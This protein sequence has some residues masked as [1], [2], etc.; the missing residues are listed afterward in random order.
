MTGL[1][2]AGVCRVQKPVASPSWR[3]S[4]TGHVALHD[5]IAQPP[6]ELARAEVHIGVVEPLEYMP[7]RVAGRLRLLAEVQH[8]HQRLHLSLRLHIA[9]HHAKAHDRSAVSCQEAWDNRMERT[10]PPATKLAC[11]GEAQKPWPRFCRLTPVPGT[12]TP[13]PHVIRL[14]EADH[15]AVAVHRR[16]IDSSAQRRVVRRER[17]RP[18]HVYL[19]DGSAR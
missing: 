5:R 10:L 13:E 12:T 4:L 9:A 16:Q 3:L 17:L 6:Y 18:A 1:A 8:A 2:H 11:P 19:T 7:A 15:H 14:N